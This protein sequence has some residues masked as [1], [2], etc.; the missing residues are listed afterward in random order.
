VRADFVNEV[1]KILDIKRKDLIE[2]DLILHQILFDLSGDR[3]FA[4]NALFKGGTCLI[5]SYFGYLRF[6]EDIDFTWIPASTITNSSKIN[7][8]ANILRT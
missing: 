8:F 1:A 3:F 4:A 2:K 5:K 7:I 6:S